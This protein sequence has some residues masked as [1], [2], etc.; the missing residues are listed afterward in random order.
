MNFQI[1]YFIKSNPA[2]IENKQLREPQVLSYLDAY[3]HFN[4]ENSA[5]DAVIIL[6]TGAGKTGVIGLVPYG[7]SNGRVLVITP[8]LVIKDHV[9]ESLDPSEPDNFWLKR[10]VLSSYTELPIVNEYDND[11]NQEELE[12]SNII[13]LNIHKLS[14]R[15]RNSLLQ[16]VGPDFFDMIIID[17]AHHSPAETWQNALNYFK[18]AKVVKVTGTPFRADRKPIEGKVITEY[19]LGRAMQQG[20]VKSLENFRLLPEQVYLT[21]DNDP[22]VKYTLEE[23]RAQGIKDENFISRSVALSKEC[24]DQIIDESIKALTSKREGSSIPH[25]IIAVACSIEHGE[26]LEGMYQQ[27]GLRAILI[28]SD[29]DKKVR[30]QLL[31]DI[32]NNRCD[33]VIHVAMLG[34]GYDHKYLSIAAIFRP[35]K[36]LAPYSQFIG[37][38]LRKIDESE[39]NRPSDNIGVVIAHRDLGLDP[40]WREYQK[41]LKISEVI[42]KVKEQE[43]QEKRLQRELDRTYNKDVAGVELDGLLDV[44]SE[45]Y[46]ATELTQE[47]EAFE[48]EMARK[49]QAFKQLLPSSSEEELRKFILSQEKPETENPLLKSPK[50]YRMLIR[51]EFNNNVHENIPAQL[52]SEFGVEKENRDFASAIPSRYNFIKNKESLDNA[53]IVTVYLNTK[54]KEQFGDRDDWVLDDFFRAEEYLEDLVKNLIEMI[55]ST[56]RRD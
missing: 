25:K 42:Q 45:Y 52:I 33:V 32:E 20:I 40:L 22:T 44:E 29:L 26:D 10:E 8:Q 31:T 51:T 38:I 28:H 50:K 16:R 35:F 7:I 24:N 47:N 49:I 2:I 39:T 14:T 21:I 36:S 1:D 19:R 17:E 3:N 43:K 30:K 9:F 18:N 11:I 53:G 27:R 4:E 23:I 15:F 12:N 37:R 55:E 48:Q 46:I 5:R 56:I 41:E 13:V 54:L 34:E 6:P